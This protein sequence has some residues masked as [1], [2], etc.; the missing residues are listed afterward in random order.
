MSSFEEKRSSISTNA[1][2]NVAHA[3]DTQ[4]QHLAGEL[5]DWKTK[6]RKMRQEL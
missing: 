6:L 3:T 1:T 4:C 2:S 5:A